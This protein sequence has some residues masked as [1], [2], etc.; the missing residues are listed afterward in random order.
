MD[1]MG[2]TPGNWIGE[3]LEWRQW[4]QSVGKAYCCLGY[5]N[6]EGKVRKYLCTRQLDT[7]HHKLPEL[8]E[9]ILAPQP[10]CSQDCPMMKGH[11]IQELILIDK[12]PE[13]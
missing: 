9:A 8:D 11:N 7:G 12:E 3:F 1:V 13:D 6:D 2:L 4:R 10:L 5:G